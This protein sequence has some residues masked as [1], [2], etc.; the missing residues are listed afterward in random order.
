MISEETINKAVDI[1]LDKILTPVLY[2]Y[3]DDIVEFVCFT[4]SGLDE[5]V[6]RKTE[7]ILY[8]VLGLKCEILDIRVFSEF[9]RVEIINSATFLFA[10]DELVKSLFEAAMIADNER[11]QSVKELAIERKAET[12]SYYYN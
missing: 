6:F 5:E 7:E 10:E 12:G 11:A 2:M 4:D 1:I 9:E 3:A 8:E